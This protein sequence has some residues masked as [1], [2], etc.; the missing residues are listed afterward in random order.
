VRLGIFGFRVGG[1]TTSADCMEVEVE[2]AGGADVFDRLWEIVPIVVELLIRVD[3]EMI[4]E[5]IEKVEPPRGRG[6][7]FVDVGE[8]S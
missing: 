8:R 2:V 4:S 3:G 7:N 6:P 5:R 1:D